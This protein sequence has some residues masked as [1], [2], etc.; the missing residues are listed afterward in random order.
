MDAVQTT[1]GN[2]TPESEVM[3][4]PYPRHLTI[5]SPYKPGIKRVGVDRFFKQEF[6]DLEVERIWKKCWQMACREED[7]PEVGDYILY[8]IAEL[9]FIVMRTAADEIRAYWNSCPHR[10]RKLREFE[11]H[12]VTELRCMFHGWSW[13]IDGS[14]KDIPCQWDFTG[15]NEQEISLPR[16]QTGTWGG[17]VFINPDLA[18]ESLADFLGT[19]PDHFEGANHDLSTRWKQV[20]VATIVDANWKVAQEAFIESWHVTTTHPQ[21]V[22]AGRSRQLGGG[23]WDDFGNWM[24]AAPNT[25][26][27]KQKPKPSWSMITEDQQVAIDSYFD[28]HLNEEPSIVAHAGETYTSV[29][30]NSARNFYRGV[31]GDKIDEYHDVELMGGGMVH[32]FPNFHPWSEFSRIQ[33]RFRPYRSDPNRSIMDVMLLAPWPEDKPRPAPAK[34]HWLK[35][36][37]DTCASPELGQLARI[38]LQDIANMPRVQEGLKSSGTGYVIL[39]EHHEAPVRHLHE[40]YEKWMDLAEGE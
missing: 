33:Y 32:V 2:E 28:R 30:L 36:G 11:G 5:E 39:G 6:H 31:L 4:A 20:H 12:G 24:R 35:P 19:L 25:P 9:S 15:T 14:S 27:D 8:D 7:I 29:T 16:A 37:E 17:Y 23:R 40:L 18:A 1:A 38:F 10:G 3:S 21:L 13:N 22:F 34:V 26:S